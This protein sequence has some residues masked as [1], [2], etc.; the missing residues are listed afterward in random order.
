MLAVLLAVLSPPAFGQNA[1]AKSAGADSL[2]AVPVDAWGFMYVRNMAAVEKKVMDVATKFGAPPMSPLMMAKGMLGLFNGV[3]DAGDLLVVIM[4]SPT[5]NA[6]QQNMAILVPT[7]DFDELM[8]MLQPE[9]VEGTDDKIKSVMIQQQTTYVASKGSF[10]VLAPTVDAVKKVLASKAGM[11]GKLS[12]FQ[13]DRVNAD[14]VTL[15]MSVNTVMTSEAMAGMT[16]MFQAMNIDASM[17]A[18]IKSL[19]V[20]LRLSEEGIRLGYYSD[21]KPGSDMAKVMSSVKPTSE[22]LLTGLPGA[23]FILAFGGRTSKEAAAFGGEQ[24]AKMFENPQLA[25]APVDPEKLEQLKDMMKTM[26]SPLREIAVEICALPGGED[27]FVG[28]S[29]VVTVDGDSQQMLDSFKNLLT[30]VKGG[31]ITDEEAN[32]FLSH[33]QYKPAAETIAGISVDHVTVALDEIEDIEE[34]DVEGI[35]QVI[36]QEGILIRMGAVDA[37][38]VIATFGGGAGQFET[39]AKLVKSGEAPLAKDPGI[40]KTSKALAASRHSEGYLAVDTLIRLMVDIGEAL[41]EDPFPVSMP[42]INAPVGMVATAVS[43]SA[44]QTDIFVPMELVM[45][46]R[47]VVQGMMGGAPP[48]G[49]PPPGESPPASGGAQKAPAAE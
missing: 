44:Q 29:K 7:T 35:K 34:E 25:Q 22:S 41:D 13:K 46:F 23:P 27:G 49:S 8:S 11:G 36:G 3:N 47:T 38:R 17:L 15:W 6:I 37:R 5:V 2:S 4:P 40:M 43:S 20:G 16:A 31:L 19:Q 9:P 1:P 28:F 14:D 32:A 39:V 42:K 30:L 48:P 26:M 24:L 21:V 18:E 10:A 33:V 12:V 45:E